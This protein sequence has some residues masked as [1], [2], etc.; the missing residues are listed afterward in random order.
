MEMEKGVCPAYISEINSDCDKQIVLLMI[1]NE[2][3]ESWHYPALKN[4]LNY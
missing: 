2:E 1:S 4:Y 3:K